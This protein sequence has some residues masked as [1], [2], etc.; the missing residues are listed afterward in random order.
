MSF[1]ELR[2]MKAEKA[3]A[4]PIEPLPKAAPIEGQ[5]VA[6]SKINEFEMPHSEIKLELE[7]AS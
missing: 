1:A 2:A 7:Y 4:L 3:K 6:P 5:K